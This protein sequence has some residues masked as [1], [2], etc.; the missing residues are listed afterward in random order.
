M[1][2]RSLTLVA[3]LAATLA[4]TVAVGNAAANRLSFDERSFRITWSDFRFAVG[5]EI[6]GWEAVH[7]ALTLEGTF[8]STTFIKT[9][10]S[11]V[12]SVTRATAGT[13]TGGTVTVL[14]E[15]LPWELTYQSFAGTLPN[16][17]SLLF[18]VIFFGVR[19]GTMSHSCL[20]RSST[21]HPLAWRFRPGERLILTPEVP[22]TIPVTGTGCEGLEMQAGGEG[23]V[24]R[25]GTS[26]TM[27]FS[28]I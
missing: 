28:L 23:F 11:T 15:S 4:L 19:V 24:A 20:G 25:L 21:V 3:T 14:L 9:R 2:H 8:A 16:V 5:N 22:F 1:G 18:D 6:S 12:A 10:G 13:C 7:C 27:R 26:T 17:S